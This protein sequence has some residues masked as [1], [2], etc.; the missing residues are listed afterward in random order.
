MQTGIFLRYRSDSVVIEPNIKDRIS[1]LIPL[2]EK[3]N[4]NLVSFLQKH[5]NHTTEP[6]YSVVNN[7]TWDAATLELYTQYERRGENQ[8]GEYTKRAII[9]LLKLLTRGDKD[10]HFDWS[11]VRR[12]LIDNIEYLAPMPDRGYISDGKEIM[13]DENGAYYYNDDKMGRVGVHGIKTLSEEMLA[14]YINET[15]CRYGKL[16]RILRY[17]ALFDIAHEYT[18]NPTDFP[19]KLS[20]VLFDNNGETNYLGWQ[21]QMPTPFDFI[22]IQWYPRSPYS[23]PEWLGS[24]L[25][26]SLSFPNAN[27]GKP[28]A[29]T[30]PINKDLKNWREAFQ[31]YKW[32][33]EIPI[34]QNILVGDEPEEYFDFF[35]RKVR[36]IN[37]NYFMQSM[38]IVP[39]SDDNGD[40]GIELARKFLS[41]MNLERDVGLSERLISRNS[42]RFSPW[43]RPIKMGDFQ[44]FNRDYML[45]FDYKNYS[46]KKW[47]ALAFMREAASSN[48]IYYAF[49]NY[50]KVVELANTANDTSKAKRWINDNIERVC[51]END[52]EWYQ[53]VVLDGEKTDPGFYLSKTERTAIAH[54]EYNYKGAK[55]HNPDNPTDWRRTQEDIVVM[56]ALARDI[57][58]TF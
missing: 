10:T 41:V 23:N 3:N 1:E 49:L 20:C 57:L 39:A 26:L 32:Q 55:T 47:Q 35:D 44:G 38:L 8:V 28:I 22:P 16:Y 13:R 36:W 30:N 17:I 5:I 18:H 25:V 19:D 4:D 43:S 15:Q 29:V 33:I 14:Y 12:Y 51:N 50:F 48:S 37:G 6:E 7:S 9:G 54:A 53:K 27:A 2:L 21:W 31:G 11:V 42:P 58:N 52:L 46:K 40:D 24:D 56:R 34:T 45:R